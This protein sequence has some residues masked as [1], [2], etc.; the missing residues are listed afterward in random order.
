[1]EVVIFI[2]MMI[3]PVISIVALVLSVLTGRRVKALK[4][5][6]VQFVKSSGKDDAKKALDIFAVS[7][8]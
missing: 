7:E 5:L 8:L 2:A 1:M 3:V 6:T 4:A